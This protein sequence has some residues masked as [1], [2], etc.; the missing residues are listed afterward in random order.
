MDEIFGALAELFC[1]LYFG[2]VSAVMPNKEFGKRTKFVLNFVCVVITFAVMIS[3]VLGIAFLMDAENSRDRLLGTVLLSVGCGFV[4][5]HLIIFTVQ[6]L[7]KRKR[8]KDLERRGIAASQAIG[9]RVHVTVDRKKGSVHPKHA[10]MYY[11]LNY[12]YVDG[13]IGG[14]G[15]EQDAYIVGVDEP[16]DEFDGVVIAVIHRL[17]DVEDKWVVAPEGVRFKKD[18][19]KA[20]TDFQEKF[21]K[22]VIFMR[23]RKG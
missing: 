12:G 2:M 15:E 17:D 4:V 6:R 11:E 10:D 7:L 21:F 5:L 1:E 23:P 19:I 14:D 22:N 20:L 3:I 16:L 13:V 8:V 9:T 18:E